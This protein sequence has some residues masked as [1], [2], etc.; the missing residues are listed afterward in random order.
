MKYNHLSREAVKSHSLG[1]ALADLAGLVRHAEGV[2]S[3]LALGVRGLGAGS[4]FD[5]ICGTRKSR[6]VNKERGDDEGPGTPN[7]RR[8][9]ST[10]TEIKMGTGLLTR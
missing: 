2:R 1:T 3:A 6:S 9:K 10:H 5:L 8:I 4:S 7:Q